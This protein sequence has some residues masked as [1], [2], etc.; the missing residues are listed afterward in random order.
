MKALRK[1][2]FDGMLIGDHNPDMVTGG[3][4]G[5]IYTNGYI[6]A[7]IERANGEFLTGTSA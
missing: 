2:N 7:L 5:Q 3:W 4:S 6:Q 1:V